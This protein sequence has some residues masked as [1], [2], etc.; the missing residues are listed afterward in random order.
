MK[1]AVWIRL[2]IVVLACTASRRNFP[3]LGSGEAHRLSPGS[4]KL[5]TASNTKWEGVV[6]SRRHHETRR[7]DWVKALA[8]PNVVLRLERTP[9]KRVNPHGEHAGSSAFRRPRYL[10]AFLKETP[11]ESLPPPPPCLSWSRMAWTK[12]I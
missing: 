11:Q 2:L 4:P 10:S 8:A 6:P 9:V 12:N 3:V 7:A 1:T 5:R